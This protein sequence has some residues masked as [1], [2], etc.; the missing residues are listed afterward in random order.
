MLDLVLKNVTLPEGIVHDVAIHEGRVHHIGAGEHTHECIDCTRF[1]C[2][3]GAV[4]MHV[5]MRGGREGH[6]EDWKTGSMSALAGGVT[7]VVDQPN[8]IPPLIS[9]TRFIERVREASKDSYCHFAINGGVQEGADIA[10][11]WDAGAMAF[12]EIFLA[13]STHG[14]MLSMD[15]LMKQVTTVSH[16]GALCTL[17]VEEFL[18]KSPRTLEEHDRSRSTAGEAAMV[19]KVLARAPEHPPLHFCHLSSPEAVDAATTTFEVAPHHLIL[20]LEDFNSTDAR[21]KVNPP[22]RTDHVRRAL[23]SR[24]NRID[25]LAS[26][27]APHTLEEKEHPFSRAPAGL[28]GVETMI[29]LLLTA[30]LEKKITLTSLIEKTSLAPSRILGTPPRGF[31]PGCSADFALFPRKKTRV[32]AEMLHSRS[33]W[34]PYEGREAIFPEYVIMD[35]VCVYRS[36]EFLERRG[37]WLHG[38]GYIPSDPI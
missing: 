20:S 10:G 37:R 17:H 15:R 3:P 12:G 21:G 38:R 26:D 7:L 5:H 33:G 19:E 23:L 28:P 11:L 9:R 24:W 31:S 36:G 29:P 6:K 16:L 1:F 30:V 27:H 25:V 14:S 8:S 18:G 4:D 34:T 2:L 35:G 32:A 22:L 13:V